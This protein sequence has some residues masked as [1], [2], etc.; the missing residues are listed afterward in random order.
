MDGE[1]QAYEMLEYKWAAFHSLDPNGMVAC[2]SGTAA[3]HLAFEALA[4]PRALPV[5]MPDLCMIACPRAAVMA[6][7]YPIFVDCS[8]DLNINQDILVRAHKLS[9][10]SLLAVHNYG[11]R[12]NMNILSKVAR[13]HHFTL[14]EDLAEAHGVL[15]HP[16]TEVACWSFYKNKIVAGEEG[17]AVWFKNIG[18]AQH[19]RQLR[20]LGFTDKHDFSHIPRGCNYRMS[21]CHARLILESLEVARANI[22]RRRAIEQEYDAVCPDDWRQPPREV[23]WV[24]DMR[25]NGLDYFKQ[26]LIIS[27]LLSHG[28]Q[29]RHC[30]KPARR[31]PEWS[32]PHAVPMDRTQSDIASMEVF[33]LPV[34]P[35]TY[36]EGDAE[37]AIKIIRE[38]A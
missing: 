2:S 1:M 34:N 4:L 27:H 5:L 24:Y 18:S 31:Q 22:T 11:R 25:I 12:C 9:A 36:R 33:Y 26:N 32:V 6:G 28:I 8:K 29:A 19:A 35:A 3:L 14:M 37:K 20:N 16:D 21:N 30:F 13:D 10:C 23:V 15:P 38:V 17:G 7:H